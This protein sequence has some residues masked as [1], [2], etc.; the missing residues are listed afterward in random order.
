MAF[1]KATKKQAK[2]RMA[3]N[4]PSGSGKTF[5]ALSIAKGLGGKIAVIDTEHA[6]ASKYADRF[7]FDTDCLTNYAPKNYIKAIHEA[8]AAGYSVIIIDSLTHAWNGTG[9]VLEIVDAA[10]SRA[11]GNTYAGWKE[12]TPEQNALVEAIL[13]SPCHIIATMRAKTEYALEKDERTGKTAPRKIG[14]APVQRD[15]M[16]YEFDVSAFLDVEHHL[17]IDKTRCPDLAGKV[18]KFPG[19]ELGKQLAAWLSDGEPAPIQKPALAVVP[20]SAPTDS[21]DIPTGEPSEAE[22]VAARFE[23]CQTLDEARKLAA[24]MNSVKAKFGN[25]WG[26]IVRPAATRAMARLAAGPLQAGA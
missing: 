26:A 19:E 24:E 25:D 12:G 7:D 18:I 1:Q 16:E 23:E 2:L 14:M 21:G 5:S 11:R 10:A 22:K 3:L 4:G 17:C 8:E 6:S 9:G 15:G 13:Q 20:Q